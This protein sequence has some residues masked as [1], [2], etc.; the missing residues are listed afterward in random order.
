MKLSDNRKR[1][2]RFVE[3]WNQKLSLSVPS[4]VLEYLLA[5]GTVH[6]AGGIVLFHNIIAELMLVSVIVLIAA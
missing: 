1:F 4:I 2:T 6:R 5:T 3:G